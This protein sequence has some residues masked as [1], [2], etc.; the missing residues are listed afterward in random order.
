MIM[1]SNTTARLMC[2]YFSTPDS[3]AFSST[4]DDPATL[5]LDQQGSPPAAVA[6]CAERSAS[7]TVKEACVMESL[8]AL[9]CSSLSVHILPPIY[10]FPHHQ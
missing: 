9:P 10:L 5:T 2:R 3:E 6:L 4:V 1:G 8:W 7:Y